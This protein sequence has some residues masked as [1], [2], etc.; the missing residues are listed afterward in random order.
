MGFGL[1]SVLDG[2][3]GHIFD[4]ER[5][6]ALVAAPLGSTGDPNAYRS[7]SY[8]LASHE[9]TFTDHSI[10]LPPPFPL[11]PGNHALMWASRAKHGTY[12]FNPD[13]FPLMPIWLIYATYF[14]IDDLYWFQVIDYWTYLYFLAIA[15]SFF[16]SCTVEHFSEQG[17]FFPGFELNVGENGRPLNGSSWIA[18]PRIASKFQPLWI[19]VQ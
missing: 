7:Y 5:S 17:G 12:E 10:Y 14:A 4:Q 13:D 15:D 11:P 1:A 18:D 6:A 3:Q 16:F 9:G 2:F 8:Y 19:L